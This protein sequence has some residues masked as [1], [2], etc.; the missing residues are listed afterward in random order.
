MMSKSEETPVVGVCKA[1]AVFD[2]HVDTVV[3]AIEIAASR[4]FVAGAV[5]KRRVKNPGQFLYDYRSF[6]K[7]ACLQVDIDVFL[8][9]V[10]VMIFGKIRLGTVLSRRIAVVLSIVEAL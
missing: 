7:I 2:R 1:L 9:D 10:H 5:W 8:L 6:R 4:G 3:R